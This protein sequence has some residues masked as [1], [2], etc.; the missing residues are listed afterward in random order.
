MGLWAAPSA[1]REPT[2]PVELWL[3]LFP[4]APMFGLRWIGMNPAAFAPNGVNS[5]MSNA[6]SPG[7]GWGEGMSRLMAQP[8]GMAMPP[9]AAPPEASAAPRPRPAEADSE[10][11]E[12][13]A[14]KLGMTARGGFVAP[15]KSGP[16]AVKRGKA[17]SGTKSDDAESDVKSEATQRT[18]DDGPIAPEHLFSA[19]PVNPDDLT[20]IYGIGPRL[21]QLLNELGVYH[22]E[23]IANFTRAELAWLDERLFVIKGRAERDR[24]V[25]GAKRAMA[26]S[27]ED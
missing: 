23:Q 13:E 5:A 14:L 8:M 19:P 12:R 18:G 9:I 25:E 7:A 27:A 6:L 15:A 3:S 21:Q 26:D 11:A 4:I 17:K 1:G 10:R 22:F 24:W 16:G 2:T 20:K